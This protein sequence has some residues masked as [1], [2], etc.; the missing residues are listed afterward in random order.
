MKRKLIAVSQRYVTALRKH[1]LG[2][3][4]RFLSLKEEAR[5]HSKGL[6]NAIAGAER[7]V[8]KSVKIRAAV[9]A[10][11]RRRPPGAGRPIHHDVLK[12]VT[13]DSHSRVALP[14]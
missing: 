9:R 12:R 3:K 13:C 5:S 6:K 1:L 10:Q 2:I 4:V 14:A 8:V 11:A 7:L